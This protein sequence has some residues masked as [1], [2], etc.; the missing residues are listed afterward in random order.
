MLLNEVSLTCFFLLPAA[1]KT[2][3]GWISHPQQLFTKTLQ[4]SEEQFSLD[5]KH[6]RLWR[7]CPSNT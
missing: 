1:E 5:N 3:V 2:E 6:L 4:S 7:N